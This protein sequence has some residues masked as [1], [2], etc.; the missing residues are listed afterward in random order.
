MAKQIIE[1]E[2]CSHCRHNVPMRQQTGTWLANLIYGCKLNKKINPTTQENFIHDPCPKEQEYLDQRQK[3]F[4]AGINAMI[5]KWENG[6]MP[7][8]DDDEFVNKLFEQ[9]LYLK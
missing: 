6:E 2:K 8:V 4:E 7:Q 5:E 1:V 9:Y 3:D